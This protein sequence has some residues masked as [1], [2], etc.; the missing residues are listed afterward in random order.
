MSGAI[1]DETR[2]AA[3]L[4]GIVREEISKALSEKRDSEG[5][6]IA[7]YARMIGR[8]PQTVRNHLRAFNKDLLDM[9]ITPDEATGKYKISDLDEVFGRKTA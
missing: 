7:E 3:L 1:T 5:V 8:T 9:A 2:L 6:T 4:R